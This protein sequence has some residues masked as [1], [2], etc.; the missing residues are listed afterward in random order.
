MAAQQSP[1]CRYR[2]DPLDRLAKRTS[3]DTADTTLFYRSDRLNTQ[4]QGA[5]QYSIL[6]VDDHLLAQLQSSGSVQE[7]A[8]LATDRQR[9]VL[10]VIQG[11][12]RHAQAYTAYGHPA[13]SGLNSLLGY[14]GEHMDPVTGHY[15]LG[16]GYRA[17]N[18]VLMRFN[19]PDRKSPFEEGGLNTYA[20]CQGD[21]VNY[22]DPTGQYR[23]WNAPPRFP[24][25]SIRMHRT[26][27]RPP[28][29]RPG[30]RGTQLRSSALDLTMTSNVSQASA[31]SSVT[32]PRVTDTGLSAPQV[33]KL[34]QLRHN[35]AS[36]DYDVTFPSEEVLRSLNNE[37]YKSFIKSLRQ[38]KQAHAG[39]HRFSVKTER[40]HQIMDSIERTQLREFQEHGA[41]IFANPK[42]RQET[43]YWLRNRISNREL[44]MSQ[45]RA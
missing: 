37:D 45:V 4:I 10:E 39:L 31:H 25:P 30:P 40:Y 35:P 22:Q 21:P 6:Q 26:L 9:S 12:E 23:F 24:R 15:L 1:L 41:S 44:D 5:A 14:A 2:Y 20:Y 17:F 33:Q 38:V 18:P 43:I 3:I 7:I 29:F 19:S 36:G 11:S 34:A 27:P 32:S 8:V 13:D 16:N 42:T 28:P